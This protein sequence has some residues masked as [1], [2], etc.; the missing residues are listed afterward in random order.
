MKLACNIYI[1]LIIVR[2]HQKKDAIDITHPV[3]KNESRTFS[4]I[5][6]NLAWMLLP[7][8]IIWLDLYM[9]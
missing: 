3:K 9:N 8:F 5:A 4:L 7:I 1:R 2:M 6:D